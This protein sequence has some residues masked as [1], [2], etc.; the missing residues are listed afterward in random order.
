M[1]G[2]KPKEAKPQKAGEE[3]I[4]K[5]RRGFLK[6]VGAGIVGAA[7]ATALEYPIINSRGEEI[8]ALNG[9]VTS[10]NQQAQQHQGQ[11]QDL[12]LQLNMDKGFTALGFDEQV[13]VEA[14]AETIIPTDASGP[15][16][17]EAGAIYF[18]DRQLSGDYGK[19]SNMYNNPPFVMPG[20]SGPITVDGVTYPQGTPSVPYHAGSQYQYSI[21]LREFWRAGLI[22]TQAYSQSAY[23]GKFETL[24]TD[25]RI[26]VLRDLY[27][28]KPTSFNDIRP[29]DF[30]G[31]LIF[32]TWSG[33][34]MDPLYG[35]NRGMIGWK[36]VGFNGTN[37]G[38]LYGE[39]L[40][41]TDLMVSDK[42][43]RLQPA[44]LGQW[45]NIVGLPGG[46]EGGNP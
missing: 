7:A 16:A 42:P 37:Y 38:E 24:G 4:T 18:I 28:N 44:S 39:G 36:H 10:L 34:L 15:G 46:G 32:M 12:S 45:Q 29:R 23:G 13:L 31:E 20:L 14:M 21:P 30:F 8:T 11:I 41:V 22:A 26:Q 43:V 40:K 35:G 33:F 9:Q 6:V 1:N 19:N 3:T 2:E 17:K 27:D 25:Q 5:G